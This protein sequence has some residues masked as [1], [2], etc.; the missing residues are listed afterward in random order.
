MRRCREV[1]R[2]VSS[3]EGDKGGELLGSR[4]GGVG[5]GGHRAEWAGKRAHPRNQPIPSSCQVERWLRLPS[6]T[7]TYL[8]NLYY[9]LWIN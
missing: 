2:N 4:L 5:V 8:L 9:V 7:Q 6:F 1:S 3:G